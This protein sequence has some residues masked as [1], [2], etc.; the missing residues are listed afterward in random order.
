MSEPVAVP[1]LSPEN[2]N[3]MRP[4][5]FTTCLAVIL[6]GLVLGGCT[7]SGIMKTN[8]LS[9]A[10]CLKH[11]RQALY[12]ADFTENLV[13]SS[14]TATASGRHAGYDATLYCGGGDHL[15]RVE[16]KGLDSDQDDWYR[17]VIIRKF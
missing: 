16:V 7:S 1:K 10:S 17:S 9:A 11:A 2:M 12:D 5:F 3:P 14:E 6:G 8:D 15:I 13:V 4:P